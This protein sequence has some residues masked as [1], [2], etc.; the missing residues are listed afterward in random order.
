MR[1]SSPSPPG[2]D[3]GALAAIRDAEHRLA[4]SRPDPAPHG[5]PPTLSRATA[6]GRP[7]PV[8]LPE[9]PVCYTDVVGKVKTAVVRSK[10]RKGQSLAQ[11]RARSGRTGTIETDG[12]GVTTVTMRTKAGLITVRSNRTGRF[13]VAKSA[14]VIDRGA[15][16]FASTLKRL[17]TK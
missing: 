11:V 13:T 14:K 8:I 3:P 5:S 10:T 4:R 16:R 6:P 2:R 17:A 15:E 1:S 7:V 12:S 9:L